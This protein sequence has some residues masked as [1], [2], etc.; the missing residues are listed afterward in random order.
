MAPTLSYLALTSALLSLSSCISVC[1]T[2]SRRSS[3]V[4]TV[5]ASIASSISSASEVFYPLSIQYTAD[6]AH[7]ASSSAQSSTCSVEPGTAEDVGTIVKGGG[8]SSN[9]GFSS[10]AGV[11]ISMSRFGEVIYD[12]A[13]STVEIGAG[14]IWDDVYEALAPYAVNVVGGRVTGVGVAGFTLGGGY[15]WKSNQYGLTVDTIQAYEL[16]LPNGTVTTV[17]SDN[18]DL[19]WALKGIVTKFTLKTFPQTEVWGGLITITEPYLNQTAAAVASFV[20]NTTDP[21]AATIPTFNFVLGAPG[22]SL[23]LFYDDPTPP[24][25]IF[26]EFLAIPYFTKDVS[27][28]SFVSL[29][30]SAPANTTSGLRG[31]FNTVSVTDYSNNLM[32]VIIQETIKWGTKLQLSLDSGA[33]ISYDVEPFLPNMLSKGPDSAFPPTRSVTYFPTNIYYAY[34]DPLFDST[35]HDALIETA[36][37]IRAA[38]VAEGQDVDDAP[39]YGNYALYDEDLESIWGDN[40]GRLKAIKASVDPGNVMA[41]AGGFKF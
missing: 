33:F 9:P 40:V 11:Q 37:T 17:T 29:V 23:L 4:N 12:E 21:K 32:D 5:C 28:R 18:D 8:H 27:T 26:D 15:S 3:D 34:I 1:A 10:T 30:Q 38:A 39:I 14:L 36:S 7:W 25:G 6:N 35:F 20:A 19:F 16:V 41:L 2:L 22:V 31:L 24:D 13:A